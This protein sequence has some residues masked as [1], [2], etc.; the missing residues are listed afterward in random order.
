MAT[1]SRTKI[2]LFW[3]QITDGDGLGTTGWN[4]DARASPDDL[5]GGIPFNT[6]ACMSEPMFLSACGTG[7]AGIQMAFQLSDF[8]ITRV[9]PPTYFPGWPNASGT[10]DGWDPGSL[11]GTATIAGDRVNIG[12]S[13][14]SA[15]SVT[16]WKQGRFCVQYQL[17][18]DIFS[19][20]AGAGIMRSGADLTSIFLGEKTAVDHIGGAMVQGGNVASTPPYQTS[21][22]VF[23]VNSSPSP[24]V[25]ASDG[26]IITLAIAIVPQFNY[27]PSPFSAVKLPDLICCPVTRHRA[28]QIVTPGMHTRSPAI[29]YT[30]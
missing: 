21:V 16:G 8:L 28:Q 23:G 4:N 25:G 3:Y 27:V 20:L 14:G 19:Q 12:A 9:I 11:L 15:Q 24:L 18:Y 5:A 1:L 29:R 30:R 13:P 2:C 26:S 22:N 17:H 6:G 10:K 7:D